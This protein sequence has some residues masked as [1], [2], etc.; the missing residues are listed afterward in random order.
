MCSHLVTKTKMTDSKNAD[1][2]L[3]NRKENAT[4]ND[5]WKPRPVREVPAP[6]SRTATHAQ[7]RARSARDRERRREG[8]GER[9]EE[10][11]SGQ[12]SRRGGGRGH[13]PL[14]ERVY[15]REWTHD[16]EPDRPKRAQQGRK[17]A[18]QTSNFSRHEI[19]ARTLRS[20]RET[21]LLGA[22]LSF[23]D[24]RYPRTYFMY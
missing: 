9:E 7:N 24:G 5:S 19:P 3:P 23:V 12:K 18:E 13:G 1:A 16:A 2:E 10:V 15:A 14:L 11:K 8:G 22:K 20:G 17:K 21:R 4:P 6:A